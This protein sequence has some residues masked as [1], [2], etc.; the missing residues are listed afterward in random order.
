MKP[1]RRLL[2]T[3]SVLVAVSGTLY[4]AGGSTHSKITATPEF[5]PDGH[6]RLHIENRSRKAITALAAVGTRTPI[7][8]GRHETSVRYF[9]SVLDPLLEKDL[10][11]GQTYAFTFFGPNPPPETMRRKV[12]LKAALFGDG[13][14]WGEPEWVQRLLLRRTTAETHINNGLQILATA[15]AS[16]I[17]REAIV[18]QAEEMSKSS[19]DSASTVEEKQMVQQVYREMILVLHHS[20]KEDGTV[21]SQNDSINAAS[22]HLMARTRRLTSVTQSVRSQ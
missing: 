12:T 9:D 21:I 22:N 15:R 19:Y 11:P 4:F 3:L 6:V 1:I 10:L 8:P 16:G 17:T 2:L 7:R 20:T 5:L 14:V 13:S 18:R